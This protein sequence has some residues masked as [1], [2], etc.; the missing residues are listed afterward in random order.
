[1]RTP[2]GRWLSAWRC[3]VCRTLTVQL[4]RK[5]SYLGV[6]HMCL[7]CPAA[8]EAANVLAGIPEGRHPAM[9]RVVWS[10]DEAAILAAYLVGGL[11]AVVAMVPRRSEA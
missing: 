10:D 6:P 5:R 9:D 8:M 2:G 11:D 7:T 1:M 4:D 3:R